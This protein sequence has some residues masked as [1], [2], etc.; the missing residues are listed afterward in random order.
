MNITNLIINDIEI[1][2][3]WQWVESTDLESEDGYITDYDDPACVD[4][5]DVEPAGH[6]IP[7][8]VIRNEIIKYIQW[9]RE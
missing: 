2:V 7:E 1:A 5:V 3:G 6:G 8:D 9:E 4:I